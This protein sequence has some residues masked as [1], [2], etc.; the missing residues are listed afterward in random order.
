MNVFVNTVRYS[1][2]KYPPSE[3]IIIII[4]D[5]FERFLAFENCK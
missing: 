2:E 1:I 3:S 4:T 5:K